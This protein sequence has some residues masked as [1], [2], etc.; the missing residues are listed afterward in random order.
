VSYATW[1]LTLPQYVLASGYSEKRADNVL[2]TTMEYGPAKR[3]A[4]STVAPR[5]I[6]CTI[7]MTSAQVTTF[8]TFFDTT[9]VYGVLS[10]YFP[11]P[12][13]Q[14]ATLVHFKANNVPSYV[15]SG[16]EADY[17]MTLETDP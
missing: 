3:R 15:A 1:P 9:L 17:S 13:N 5:I 11:L 14:I 12:P 6:A 16:V 2:E 4:R 8:N 10:F 7:H